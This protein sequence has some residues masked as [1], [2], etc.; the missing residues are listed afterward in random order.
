MQRVPIHEG[1]GERVV[2]LC[3]VAKHAGDGRKQN[4]AIQ[5]D[6]SCRSVELHRSRDFRSQHGAELIVSLPD[7]EAVLNDSRAVHDAIE[8]P[9]ASQGFRDAFVN[10]GCVRQVE[11]PIF[12]LAS[13]TLAAQRIEPARTL[14]AQSGT[15]DQHDPRAGHALRNLL[16]HDASEPT[17]ATRDEVDATFLPRCIALCGRSS[18][19]RVRLRRRHAF[20]LQNVARSIRVPDLGLPSSRGES[21]LFQRRFD[22]VRRCRARQ[23]NDLPGEFRILLTGAPEQRGRGGGKGVVLRIRAHDDL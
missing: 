2:A 18:L 11:L 1:V 13:M 4:E 3:S 23:L 8:S 6:F 12:D 22:F 16:G 15:A 10:G 20:I 21:A 17:Q 19:R 5:L 9:M 7:D 14:C